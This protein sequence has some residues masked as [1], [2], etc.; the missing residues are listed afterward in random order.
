MPILCGTDFSE[1]A[2]RALTAA[3]YIAVRTE[4]ALDLVHVVQA[5]APQPDAEP[6]SEYLEW[7]LRQ[8]QREAERAR[9]LGA[10]VRVH[11]KHGSPDEA[12]IAVAREVDAELVV[13]GPLGG[14]APG[15]FLLGGHADRLAQ[16]AHVPVLIV[17]DAEPFKVWLADKQPLRI[18]LGADLSHSTDAA[19]AL[20][21]H[22]RRLAPC[23]VTAM[24]LYWPPQQ[25]ARLGI[26]GV[27][28]YLDPDPDVTKTLTR[29][30]THR[31]AFAG[32]AESLQVH[33]E[34]HLGR[35]GDRLADLAF[36]RKADVLVVGTRVRST[37][38]RIWEGSVSRAALHAARTSILC[39]PAPRRAVDTEVPRMRNVLAAT[40]LSPAGNAAVGL[41]YALAE[42]GGIVHLVHV[43]P[44]RDSP[45]LHP[46]DIFALEH[47]SKPDARRDETHRALAA[48]VP[49]D[50]RDRTT[51]SYA[52]ESNEVAA[53]IRQAALRLDADAICIGRRGHS[54]LARAVLGSVVTDLLAH[55]ERPVLLAQ[56]PS[57]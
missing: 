44:I 12:L 41:A 7:V 24:H 38:G 22:W 1:A 52:L 5:G 17:R 28:S 26:E 21:E 57:E 20:V 10:Q 47:A 3:A 54:K 33:V 13:I 51:R 34:P 31:L 19:M 15:T 18:V 8:L 27:R 32:E 42:A 37:F 53:A 56:S 4:T 30:L 9:E 14:R 48:L 36:Q 40:D 29:E 45:P 2:H 25:F 43:V 50:F 35:I 6:K 11:L 16:C 23:D 49:A 39:V 55:T 46:H